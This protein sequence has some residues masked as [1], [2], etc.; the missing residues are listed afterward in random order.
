[1]RTFSACRKVRDRPPWVRRSRIRFGALII[2]IA[3]LVAP[4]ASLS[5]DCNYVQAG[6]G[7]NVGRYSS[8]A[9]DS[10]GNPRISYFESTN[11]VLA[12]AEWTGSSWSTSWIDGMD[13]VGYYTSLALNSSGYPRV[14]YYDNTNNNLKYAVWNGTSWN[15]STVDSGGEVG[16]YA[17]LVL[18]SD[19]P[20]ISY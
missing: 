7:S 11:T 5:W 4:C 1:M 8:L 15:K 6:A 14:A 19:K 13:D 9:L 17:S 10:S 20:R 12:Y 18:D 2:L 3:A 16:T